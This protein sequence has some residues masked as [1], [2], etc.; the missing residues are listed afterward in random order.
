MSSSGNESE[1]SA[2]SVDIPLKASD[3]KDTLFSSF[4]VTQKSDVSYSPYDIFGKKE[5]KVTRSDP[6]HRLKLNCYQLIVKSVMN[7]E[8][9]TID[10]L[11][12]IQIWNLYQQ[13]KALKKTH[14]LLEW[15]EMEN[16][17]NMSKSDLTEMCI[18]ILGQLEKFMSQLLFMVN[19]VNRS[20]KKNPD[21][22]SE[23][24][25]QELFVRYAGIFGLEIK[26]VP[27]VPKYSLEIN[28]IEV[29]VEPDGLAV[30]P[31]SNT[32]LAVVEVKKHYCREFEE[33]N[34]KRLHSAN[35]RFSPAQHINSSLKGQH[36]AQLLA[37]MPQSTY[38]G[39]KPQKMYGFIVQG[40]E[41]CVTS[42]T[43]LNEDFLNDLK[44]GKL[45]RED[46]AEMRY[47]TNCNILSL[48]GR[49][50]LLSTLVEMTSLQAKL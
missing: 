35:K 37:T 24:M 44:E 43:L 23:G 21:V 41:V 12:N 2:I 1:K 46:C 13:C 10:E 40:T 6:N 16:T 31:H 8:A 42:F 26:C 20:Q 48:Q 49:L 36:L 15:M 47:S 29:Q 30:Y 4:R 25:Y 28:N 3:W 7:F 5:E 27:N 34:V 19:M 9:S 50:G 14:D 11:S 39:S 33:E 32:L 18:R 22:L 45:P 38:Y 17:T